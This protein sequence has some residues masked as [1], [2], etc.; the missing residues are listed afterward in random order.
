MF[1]VR[2]VFGG[3]VEG[4]EKLVFAAVLLGDLVVFGV[5]GFVCEACRRS[6]AAAR[7]S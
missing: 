1:H 2:H 6:G 5:N 7:P 3:D 4:L